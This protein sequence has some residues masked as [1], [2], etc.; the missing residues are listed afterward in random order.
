MTPGGVILGID[1]GTTGMGYALLD[2]RTEPPT[3]LEHGII[4]TPHGGTA[5]DRLASIADAIDGLIVAH[6][7]SALA[8]ERLYFNRNART[9]MAVAEARGIALLCAAKRGLEVAEY[10]PQEVK[11]SVAGSGSAD[12]KHVQRMLAIVLSLPRPIT[13]DNVADAVAIALTHVQR[14]RFAA[15]IAKAT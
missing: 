15:A 2:R 8:L 4:P 3:V 12:K 10:T 14:S 1:P 5:G 9:A 6:G 11:L 7:A 13:Q